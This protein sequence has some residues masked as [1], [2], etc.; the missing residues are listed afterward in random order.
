[1]PFGRGKRFGGNWNRA[2]DAVLGG[3]Q[4]NGIITLTTGYPLRLT[5]ANA[6]AGYVRPNNNGQSAAKSGPVVDRLEEYFDTS[7]FSQ[8]EPFTFGNVGRYLPDVRDPASRNWDFFLFKH[9]TLTEAVRLQFRAEFFNF[10]NTP[11]FGNPNVAVNNNNFGRIT[12]QAN[13]PRQIQFGLKL[14]W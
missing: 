7:V 2:V 13:S 14:L 10:T 6:G 1:M 11:E 4:L 5:A 9:F 3:W 8:P 12:S